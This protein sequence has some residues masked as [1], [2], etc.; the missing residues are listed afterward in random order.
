[1]T[2]ADSRSGSRVNGDVVTAVLHRKVSQQK[3]PVLPMLTSLQVDAQE[4]VIS[5]PT[6]VFCKRVERGNDAGKFKKRYR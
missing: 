6:S 4:R 1:M 5:P 3:T 2:S